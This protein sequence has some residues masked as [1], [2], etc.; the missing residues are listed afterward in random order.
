MSD[1]DLVAKFPS[2]FRVT[3]FVPGWEGLLRTLCEQL[4][5]IERLTGIETYAEDLKEKFG[6]LRITH[7]VNF[8]HARPE[9]SAH[10]CE[11]WEGI[12]DALVEQASSST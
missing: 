5:E 2:F 9:L 10:A 11:I 3:Q 12:I 4:Q 6:A 1:L 8:E 7:Q